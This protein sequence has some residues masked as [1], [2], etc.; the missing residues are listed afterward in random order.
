MNIQ[1]EQLQGLAERYKLDATLLQ[2]QLQTIIQQTGRQEFFI[3]RSAGQAGSNATAT[4][5]RR[6]LLAFP[7]PD[8][9]VSFA[10][11]NRLFDPSQPV[12]TRRLHVLQLIEATL[13]DPDV[14]MLVLA[15][16]TNVNAGHLPSGL[17]LRR[18][19]L[20]T[21]LGLAPDSAHEP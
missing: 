7:S 8:T 19:Q 1:L 9:A 21:Q 13:R 15:D 16:D 18:D 3:F 2:A 20:L 10:Q 17:Q 11:R 14:I 5:R 12:R 6:T 4:S